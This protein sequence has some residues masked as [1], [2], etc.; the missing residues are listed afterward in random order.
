MRELTEFKCP[1][2]GKPLA[3]DEYHHAMSE[4]EKKAQEKQD[5]QTKM[6]KQHYEQK[7]AQLEEKRKADIESVK[8]GFE[9]QS[10]ML[11]E[12]R[13]RSHKAQL[14]ELTKHYDTLNNENQEQYRL[15]KERLEESKK[16][17]LEE[18]DRQLEQLRNDQNRSKELAKE[19][20]RQ[21]FEKERSDLERVITEKDIQISRA[22]RD[23]DSLKRQLT[24]SQPELR[25]EA[26]ERDLE[27]TLTEAFP[28]DGFRRQTRGTSS[29]DLIQRISLAPGKYAEMPIVYDNKEAK[30][31]T[32]HDVDKAKSYKDFHKT[33]YVLIVSDNLPSEIKNGYFGEKDGVFL[34]HRRIVVEV[35][36]TIRNAI[37][38]I[39]MQTESAKDRGTKESKLYNYIKGQDF[40]RKVERL[41]MVHLKLQEFQEKEE[42][43]HNRLWKDRKSLYSEMNQASMEIRTEIASI[44]QETP[45]M[46]ELLE[47]DNSPLDEEEPTKNV[48]KH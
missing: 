32:K 25:G 46:T 28:E 1:L 33:G 41:L 12:T 20:A 36:R 26:G 2:C 39:D 44:L 23:M 48:R 18:K 11:R 42:N 15:L 13:E 22:Q 3:S 19:E 6:E 7:I 4:L 34:V 35:A 29:G 9:E 37:I 14:E 45:P 38:E 43:A 21:S 31:I 16:K 8:K 40:A 30:A 47:N 10:G 5:Q 27:A 17:E 24:Q